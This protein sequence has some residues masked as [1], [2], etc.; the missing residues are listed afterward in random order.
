VTR[1]GGRVIG[2]AGWERHGQAALLRSVAVRAEARGRG[3]RLALVHAA[4]GECPV[5]GRLE[6]GGVGRVDHRVH[7]EGDPN[8]GVR[9]VAGWERAYFSGPLSRQRT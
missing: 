6:R 9:F 2:C 7:V 8:V 5:Q 1:E 3:V 4:V